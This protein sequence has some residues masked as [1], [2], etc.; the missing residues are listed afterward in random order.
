MCVLLRVRYTSRKRYGF[1]RRRETRL[2]IHKALLFEFSVREGES[3]KAAER[4]NK[5]SYEGRESGSGGFELGHRG[6]SEGTEEKR[7]SF[8]VQ[9]ILSNCLPRPP[10]SR[11]IPHQTRS[12]RAQLRDRLRCPK[13]HLSAPRFAF[14]QPSFVSVAR[15]F[16]FFFLSSWT[17][18]PSGHAI[19]S[20]PP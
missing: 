2:C 18:I 7:Q 14:S 6:S 15:F 13:R 12:H 4:E 19:Q 17:S 20:R 3:D 5:R 11:P 16:F 8:G 10:R 1:L 9:E